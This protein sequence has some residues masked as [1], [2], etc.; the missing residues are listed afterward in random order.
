MGLLSP[1]VVVGY[2]AAMGG[3]SA[4]GSCLGFVDVRFLRENEKVQ[5]ISIEH[6]K[7]TLSKRSGE[8]VSQPR[9]P[10][11]LNPHRL[12]LLKSPIEALIYA[13]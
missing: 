8:A 9:P 2:R 10:F 13:S 4:P 6:G 11:S 1:D 3:R 5:Q 12:A 7:N